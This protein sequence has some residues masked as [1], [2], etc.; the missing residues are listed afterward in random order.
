MFRSD[1]YADISLSR[2]TGVLPG[3]LV[4]AHLNLNDDVIFGLPRN[5]RLVTA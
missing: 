4:K 1:H 2:W 5:K 3:G